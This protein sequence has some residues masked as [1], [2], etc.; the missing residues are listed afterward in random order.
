MLK[1]VCSY[2]TI[3][4]IKI[5]NISTHPR[6]LPHAPFPGKLNPLPSPRAITVLRSHYSLVL[7]KLASHKNNY[8]SC[9]IWFI[10]LNIM[11][12]KFV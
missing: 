10:L 8:T 12:L 9:C 2:I 7:P 11:L 1:N 6:K 3:S 4:Q 5:Q